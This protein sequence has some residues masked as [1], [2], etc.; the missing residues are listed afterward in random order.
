MTFDA[1]DS[2][3]LLARGHRKPGTMNKTE[4]KYAQ[5]LESLRQAGLIYWWRYEAIKL[6]L[7]EGV[8]YSPDFLVVPEDGTLECH[9]VK[10]YWMETGRAKIKIAAGIY[11]MRFLAV[12]PKSKK[13]GGGWDVEYF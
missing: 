7:G 3:K 10:G 8:F 13:D 6:R 2:K 4:E 1:N 5:R 11:P 9:E 12:K